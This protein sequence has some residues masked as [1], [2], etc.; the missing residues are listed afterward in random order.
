MVTLQSHLINAAEV[1]TVT[2]PNATHHVHLDRGERGR[3]AFLE[4]VTVF[5]SR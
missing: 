3:D 4:A 2:I 5:L 1:E